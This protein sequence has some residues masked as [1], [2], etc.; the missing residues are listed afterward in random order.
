MAN[1]SHS[2]AAE[3]DS[4]RVT[5][6]AAESAA[7]S[8]DVKTAIRLGWAVAELRGRS[9]PEGARP[10]TA[11]LPPRPAHTLPLRSQRDDADARRSAVRTLASLATSLHI[12]ADDAEA[13]LAPGTPWQDVATYF[14]ARIQDSLTTRG[15]AAANGYLLARG[16]A[17]CYW[18]LGPRETWTDR[19]G[20]TGV[21]LHF[22]FGQDRRRELT[23]MLG[24]VSTGHMRPLSAAAISGSIEAW[25]RVADD[26]TWAAPPP[27]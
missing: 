15:E 27:D 22:L 8:P 10:V 20:D 3:G 6:A 17:E 11:A 26:P 25:G 5:E 4:A 12:P 23:R 2:G 13:E 9:W 24:R 21:S 19:G 7:P 18:G 16:L 14:D 1:L